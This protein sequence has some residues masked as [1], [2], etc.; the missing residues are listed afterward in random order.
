MGHQITDLI[1][2]ANEVVEE[3]SRAGMK[4]A[5]LKLDFEKT[6]DKV[7]QDFLNFVLEKKGFDNCWKK[8]I[9]GCVASTSFSVLING[10]PRDRFFGSR[11]RELSE[12]ADMLENLASFKLWEGLEDRRIWLGDEA[13]LSVKS[14]AADLSLGKS[15]VLVPFFVAVWKSSVPSKV[16]IFAWLVALK[17][18]NTVDCVQKLNPTHIAFAEHL[19][20]LFQSGRGC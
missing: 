13:E 11:G 14:M 3:T 6:Y 15:L 20:S 4:G 9:K 17:R 19:P 8:W 12:D 1:L 7:S 18:V 2:I 16:Q 10:K 5:V